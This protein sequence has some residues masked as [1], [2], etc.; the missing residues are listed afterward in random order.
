VSTP[1][2][3]PP[4]VGVLALQGAVGAHLDALVRCGVEAVAVR[5]PS[6]VASVDA[7][8]LPGGESTT[9]GHLLR[10]S[11]VGDVLVRRLAAGLPALGTCA[12]II[13]LATDV[14]DGRSDQQALG[15]IDV[16]VRRNAFGRQVASFEA[17][18]AV[19]GVTDDGPPFPGVFIRAPV[20]ASCGPAVEVLATVDGDPVAV[21]QDRVMAT[22]F[23][24]ELTGDDRVHRYFVDRLVR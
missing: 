5:T 3:G 21:R 20:V 15:A 16:A 24:P 13:L 6:E 8:V 9:M 12:G 23:H 2:S 1:P 7:V 22:A 17:P 10:T 11:G 19:A 18:L 4:R 14:I